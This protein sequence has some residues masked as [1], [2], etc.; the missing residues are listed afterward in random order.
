MFLIHKKG[1][2]QKVKR[3][4]VTKFSTQENQVKFS[5]SLKRKDLK[6]TKAMRHLMR[7]RAISVWL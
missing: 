1:K 3:V 4:K 2:L 7:G 5:S 6:L